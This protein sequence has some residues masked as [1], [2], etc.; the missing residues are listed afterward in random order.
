MFPKPVFSGQEIKP[1]LGRVGTESADQEFGMR[2]LDEHSTFH[3]CRCSVHLYRSRGS[4][5]ELFSATATIAGPFVYE[6][7]E[8]PWSY[9]EIE[10][11][12]FSV[13]PEQ[14]DRVHK[15]LLQLGQG[16]I[17]LAGVT[18][19]DLQSMGFQRINADQSAVS[20]Q[21]M[22]LSGS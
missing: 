16:T 1:P 17:K 22:N 8:R 11:S 12:R 6:A 7:S 15:T 14:L 19:F 5:K 2:I 18:L 9:W 4:D 20:R 13:R 21:T 10:L 3:E